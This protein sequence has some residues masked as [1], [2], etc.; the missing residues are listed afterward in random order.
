MARTEGR[1]HERYRTPPTRSFRSA[2]PPSASL[3][4]TFAAL[5]RSLIRRPSR[6]SGRGIS[7]DLTGA[8]LVDFNFVQGSVIRAQFAGATFQGIAGFEEATFERVARFDEATFQRD[9]L[10]GGVTFES[11]AGFD[12]ATFGGAAVF[13]GAS[14]KGNAGFT[15]AR[16]QSDAGFDG[17][18]FEGAAVFGEVT[19]EG[20]AWFGK[21]TFEGEAWFPTTFRGDAWF[22]EATFQRAAWFGEATFHRASA[23]GGA[24]VLHIDYRDRH[25]MWPD[26]WTV[27]PDPTDPGRGTLVRAEQTEEPEPAA[28]HRIRPGDNE[29]E[30]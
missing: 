15:G 27:L 21:V 23:F 9:V 3:P 13:R 1:S 6:P 14:F 25:G 19:F 8:V 5:H 29:I 17:A 16:F 20:D 18:T 30:S 28:P 7:L 2:R 24:H 10:F 4:T 26:G 12:G 22:P 11:E